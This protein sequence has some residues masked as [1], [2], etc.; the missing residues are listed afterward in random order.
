MHPDSPWRNY[1]EYRL[2]RHR[3]G[4]VSASTQNQA[5]NAVLFLYRE[6]L[7]ITLPWLEDVQRAKKPQHLPGVLTREEVK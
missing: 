3:A 2:C 6:V 5:L 1:A 4:N 7:R